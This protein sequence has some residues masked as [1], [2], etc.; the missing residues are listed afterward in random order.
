MKTKYAQ[1]DKPCPTCPYVKSTPS[2][3]WAKEEYTKLP[4][5]DGDTGTQRMELFQCHYSI[6]GLKKRTICQGWL[7]CHNGDELLA[8]RLA[9]MRNSLPDNFS[10]EPSGADV[11][12]SGKEACDAGLKDVDKPSKEAISMIKKVSRGVVDEDD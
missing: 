1:R 11:Y 9:R 4:G 8:I 12:A 7:D 10:T 6:R 3:M 5:Y 2:G